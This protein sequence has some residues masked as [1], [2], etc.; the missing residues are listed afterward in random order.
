MKVS[1]SHFMDNSTKIIIF[2]REHESKG[3]IY[4][5]ALESSSVAFG[6]SVG[7]TSKPNEDCL[8]VSM[9]GSEMVLAIADGHWGRDASEIAVS[10]A[11]DL[12]RADTRPAQDSETRARLFSLFEQVNTKLYEI[13]TSA[14]GASASETT[15]IVCHVKEAPSGKYLYWASFG[16]SYLFLLRNGEWKQLN[17]LN[18][19]WLGYLS[20][21]SENANTKSILTR[22][23]SSEARYVGVP[24]G[25]ETG[26]E[27][28]ETGDTV[29]L[30]TDGLLGSD[31]A[32][33][34]SVVDGMKRIL[35]SELSLASR[36]E[37]MIASALDRGEED[38]VSCVAASI[39]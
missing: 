33:E 38:N 17:S 27:R 18:A 36:V 32:P 26:I 5:R 34:Q 8:G 3:E 24:S 20:K 25:L 12:I 31:C 4:F 39:L 11:V 1:K 22:F 37:Q 35:K 9:S 6:T 30:C 14:P 10:K 21:L 29:F 16:D 2:G 28:L 7:V 23:L 15:L 19:F 13:A